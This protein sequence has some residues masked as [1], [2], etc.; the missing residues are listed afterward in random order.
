[1]S[2]KQ[3]KFVVGPVIVVAVLA[4]IATSALNSS[5]SYFQTVSELYAMDESG[6]LDG[7][8]IKV[9]GEV[10][11]GTIERSSDGVRFTV[12]DLETRDTLEI[13]YVGSAPLPDTLRDYAEAVVDGEY[14]GNGVF[15]GTTLQAKCASKYERELEAG[16]VPEST[17]LTP[18]NRF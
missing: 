13:H 2:G 7:K 17:E 8:R 16:V 12:V 15:T 18:P 5:M 14:A 3:L 11:P 9:M 1:M 4:W 10:V 6:T